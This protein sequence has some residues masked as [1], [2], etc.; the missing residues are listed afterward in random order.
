MHPATEDVDVLLRDCD[1]RRQRR[2]GPGGQHRNKVETAVIITH[3]PTGIHA[4][5]NE[6]RSQEQNR[7]VAIFRLR[8][9]LAISVRDQIAEP[10]EQ[11]D[12]WRSRRSGTKIVISPTHVDFPAILSEALDVLAAHGMDV[13]PAAE[14]LG[15][16]ASQLVKL[17]RAEC[18]SL[19]YVNIVRANYSL[20]PLS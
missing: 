6:R 5:A 4:E 11:S 10:Y 8:V 3:K 20:P 19:T 17:L 1:V 14:K 9:N 16:T 7:R 2:G 15:V 18:Q 12:L 13:K